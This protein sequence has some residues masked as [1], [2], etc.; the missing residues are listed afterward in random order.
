MSRTSHVTQQPCYW[1]SKGNTMIMYCIHVQCDCMVH[2]SLAWVQ[3]GKGRRTKKCLARPSTHPY[4]YMYTV[5]TVTVD[6]F[7]VLY[8]CVCV[9]VCVLLC[10]FL[11]RPDVRRLKLPEFLDW[12]LMII[13]TSDSE[14]ANDGCSLSLSLSLSL[15]SPLHSLSPLSPLHSLLPLP[16]S[17][18]IHRP[19]H[20]LTTRCP[21]NSLFSLQAR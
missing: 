11:S 19:R 7:R 6:I 1:Q 12:C 14:S 3:V 17:S 8:V 16:S 4:M 5:A 21:L 2:P 15:H 10:R 13:K 9:C 18:R 20:E